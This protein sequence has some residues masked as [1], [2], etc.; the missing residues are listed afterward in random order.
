MATY[1]PDWQQLM[2]GIRK[3]FSDK[4]KLVSGLYITSEVDKMKGVMYQEMRL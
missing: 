4:H 3:T 1:Q 2:A